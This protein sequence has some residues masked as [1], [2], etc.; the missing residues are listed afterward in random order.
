MKTKLKWRLSKLPTPSELA[1]LVNNKLVTQEEAREILFDQVTKEDAD[2]EALKKEIEFLRR[3]VEDL[4]SSRS[5]TV[6]VIEKHINHYRD[7]QWYQPY[8]TYCSASN[9]AGIATVAGGTSITSAVASLNAQTSNYTSS[10]LAG[11]IT[12]LVPSIS[13]I[14]TF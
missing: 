2:V 7:W 9:L 12:S 8:A 14:K 13:S 3:V 1:E 10:G 5:Q 6:K 4:S 11:S